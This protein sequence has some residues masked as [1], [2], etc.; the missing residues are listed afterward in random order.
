ML[1]NI[2]FHGSCQC[3]ER[4][5]VMF[6]PHVN[7]KLGSAITQNYLCKEG[8]GW[9]GNRE[10][11]NKNGSTW[12][13]IGKQI[14]SEFKNELESASEHYNKEGTTQKRYKYKN[15]QAVNKES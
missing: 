4:Y 13:E 2:K 15:E 14:T 1:N 7:N 8:D 3:C 10:I 5:S 11:K 9:R 12:E 6:G